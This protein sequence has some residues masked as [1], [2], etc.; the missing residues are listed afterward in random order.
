M[1]K[2]IDPSNSDPSKIMQVGMGFWAS[3]VMLSAVKFNLFTLLAGTSKSAKQIKELLH[4]NT[5]DR[6]IFDWLDALVSLGFLKREGV[7][8]KAIYSNASDT[9]IF[10]DNKKPSYTKN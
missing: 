5:T 8:D 6:H 2:Q 1:E 3:K 10:L 4:L 7:L 9:E